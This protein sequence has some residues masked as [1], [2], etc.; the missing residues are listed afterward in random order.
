MLVKDIY[1]A[2]V[3]EGRDVCMYVCVEG[4][5]CVCGGRGEVVMGRCECV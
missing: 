5:R 2:G 3:W 4:D 1:E